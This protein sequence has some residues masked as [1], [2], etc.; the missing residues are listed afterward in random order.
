[1]RVLLDTNIL[2]FREDNQELIEPVR[3]LF[4]LLNKLNQELFI[5]PDSYTDINNDKNSAR[6]QVTLS[7]VSTYKQLSDPP[8]QTK[9]GNYL[10]KIG[11]KPKNSH[12][13]IDTNIIYSLYRNS[14]NFLI[15]DDKGVHQKGK[16]VGLTDRIF[17]VSDALIFFNELS[18]RDAIPLPPPMI[19]TQPYNVNFSAH[20]FDD[21]RKNHPNYKEWISKE[22]EPSDFPCWIHNKLGGELGAILICRITDAVIENANPQIPKKRRVEIIL[23]IVSDIGQKIGELFL[24]TVVDYAIFNKVDEI[25]FKHFSQPFDW[26]ISL[27]SEYGFRKVSLI[28]QENG[29]EDLYLKNVIP[30]T[31]SKIKLSLVELNKEFF[32]SFCD[33]ESVK[34]YLVPIIPEYHNRQFPTVGS[35]Q[36]KLMEFFHKF[37]IEGNV[38][39]KA[40]ICQS[41]IKKMKPGDLVLFYR[42]DDKKALTTIGTIEDCFIDLSNPTEILEKVAKRTVYSETEINQIATK[43]NRIIMFLFHFALPK[44]VPLNKLQEFGIRGYYQTI[45][46]ISHDQYLQ[47]KFFSKLPE[48]FIFNRIT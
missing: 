30:T 34:K 8:D 24:R 3:Q 48:K 20:L 12:D 26:L 25:F 28:K 14:V 43:E 22:I 10:A 21:F 9:D 36:T 39:K 5:H 1:M 46:E 44:P 17:T 37:I 29:M 31:D 35:R 45:R 47:I 27:T 40:Y 19:K 6:K 41:S 38:I 15:S 32:P 23:F 13:L 7:K 42:S 33:D 4:I 16:L 2:I 11:G 18:P